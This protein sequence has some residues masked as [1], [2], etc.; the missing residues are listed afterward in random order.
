MKI[1]PV[2]NMNKNPYFDLTVGDFKISLNCS[3]IS[4]YRQDIEKCYGLWFHSPVSTCFDMWF[5]Y[6]TNL[7][8]TFK[9]FR[10]FSLVIRE[11]TTVLKPTIFGHI[12]RF[13]NKPLFA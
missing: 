7:T 4:L 6:Q 10:L 9:P 11:N 8:P 3:G 2:L 12:K 5:P 1:V 13:M